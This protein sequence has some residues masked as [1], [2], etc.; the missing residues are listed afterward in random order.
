MSKGLRQQLAD[1]NQATRDALNQIA[2]LQQK[3]KATEDHANNRDRAATHW[4]TVAERKRV[5]PMLL[6]CP[7]CGARHIEGELSD[8]PHHTHAC[9]QCGMC[10][11]PCVEFTS[12]VQYLP[13]FKDD[14][15]SGNREVPLTPT[16]NLSANRRTWYNP[17][18]GETISV[19][20]SGEQPGLPAFATVAREAP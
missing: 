6:W 3:L 13:G 17:A 5:I 8:K 2:A 1:A 14:V 18:T 10:W 15:A 20:I 12:G 4:Q 9:Q 7:A 11:R 19:S 16:G